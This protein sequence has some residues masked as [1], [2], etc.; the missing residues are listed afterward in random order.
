MYIKR[1]LR[2]AFLEADAFF[3]ALLITG[4]RQ[5]G[6]TTFLCNNAEPPR[7]FVSLDPLD[8]RM[9]AKEDPRL[10]LANNPRR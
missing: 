5:V 6:K 4:A 2:Q 10:F 3:P 1:N 7:C 8:V 9:Q